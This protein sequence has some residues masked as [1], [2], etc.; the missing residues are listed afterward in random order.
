MLLN[1]GG[2]VDKLL[3]AEQL[4]SRL[5]SGAAPGEVSTLRFLTR[6]DSLLRLTQP[7][8]GFPTG[9]LKPGDNWE[10]RQPFPVS[11]WDTAALRVVSVYR[12]DLEYRHRRHALIEFSGTLDPTVSPSGPPQFAVTACAVV[13]VAWVDPETGL[14]MDL[15]F[16]RR[17]T[18]QP[19]PG[20]GSS[21]TTIDRYQ[22]TLQNED[23]ALK[24]N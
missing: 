18:R 1:A 6:D 14:V 4:R 10:S 8:I 13:G 19:P 22:M 7:I 21:A 9:P 17:T 15:S 12:G 11:S 5:N 3:D 2:R 23:A 24:L 20:R 16:E